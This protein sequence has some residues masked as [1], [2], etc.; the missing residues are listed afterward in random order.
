MKYINDTNSCQLPSIETQT[1]SIKGA[2][3]LGEI[4]MPTYGQ[5]G[6][7]TFSHGC[8]VD[9]EDAAALCAPIV[10]EFE[11]R[12]VTDKLDSSNIKIGIDAH[13]AIIK[14][15]PKKYDPGKIETGAAMD[16]SNEYEVIYYKKILNG[17]SIIEIDKL[18]NVLIINGTDYAKQ[19]R[20]AL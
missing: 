8:R 1:D 20:A 4:D 5:I 19:I 7:M 14:G 3:I 12:W 10:Q 9:G 6:S 11:V 2:G 16:G 13:K 15:I 17:K 18:N